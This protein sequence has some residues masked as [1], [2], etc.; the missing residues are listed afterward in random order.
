MICVID[1][2]DSFVYNIVQYFGRLE[3]D[4]K[5]FRN[6]KITVAA[7]EVLK[8][9]AVIIS[10]G[11]GIPE[12]AGICIN[13]CKKLYSKIP[14]LGICLGHQSIAAA[15]GGKV[16]PAQKVKHGKVSFIHHDGKTIFKKINQ[17]FQ[18]TRYHSLIVDKHNFPDCFEI[19]AWTSDGIIMGIRHKEYPVEGIQFHPESILTS[20]GLKIFKNFLS[21]L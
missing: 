14:L 20:E 11:P 6:D 17:P 18:A 12:A 2:Y 21:M 4:V 9:E 13:L 1:N 5:V 16:V 15:L 10:P 7:I 3:A 8:P 19:S